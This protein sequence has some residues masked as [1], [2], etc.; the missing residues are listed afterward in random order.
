MFNLLASV[1]DA[2]AAGIGFGM[3]LVYIVVASIVFGI[4]F[5]VI[6]TKVKEDPPWFAFIPILNLV[7]LL[8]IARKEMWWIILFLIP[9][10]N[11]IATIIVMMAVAERTN[12]PNWWGILM[13]VPCLNVLVPFILAFTGEYGE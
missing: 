8:K 6:A 3:M 7:L 10:V 5:F 12:K 13:I 2:A 9:F 1:S 11:L 4:P